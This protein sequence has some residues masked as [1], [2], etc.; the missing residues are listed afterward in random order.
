M[1][2]SDNSIGDNSINE[3]LGGRQSHT[4]GDAESS[5]CCGPGLLPGAT[6]EGPTSKASTGPP[7][8]LEA[9]MGLS[10]TIAA[11]LDC[12]LAAAFSVDFGLGVPA[13]DQRRG[14]HTVEWL[15]TSI[16]VF[17]SIQDS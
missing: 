2:L 1:A 9:S 7:T 14:K 15:E 12:P 11:R 6:A 5:R 16:D 8:A 4:V 3:I 10:S 13:N 17:D